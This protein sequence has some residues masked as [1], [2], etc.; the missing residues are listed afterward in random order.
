MHAIATTSTLC[1]ALASSAFAQAVMGP[2]PSGD[3]MRVAGHMIAAAQHPCPRLTA[4]SRLGDGSIRATCSN[5]EVYRLA[6]VNGED[7]AMKC[8][9]AARV[10]VK[11]C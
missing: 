5:G 3:P 7:V 10:G 6:T 1:V 2:A 4:A 9:A 11:G 8:S